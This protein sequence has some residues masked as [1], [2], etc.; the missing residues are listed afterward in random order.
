MQHVRLMFKKRQ[1]AAT[2]EL[3]A[4]TGVAAF[5]IGFGARTV[6]SAF[7]VFPNALWNTEISGSA[8][9]KLEDTWENVVLLII[10]EISFIGRVLFSKMH[11]R[12]QQAK[13]AYFSERG[14]DPNEHTFGDLSMVLV[15]DFGQLEPI[16]DWSLCDTGGCGVKVV[17]NIPSMGGLTPYPMV[18]VRE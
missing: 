5:N 14:L 17:C 2:V 9:R 3:T 16:D 18:Y 7:Q 10:D 15:G 6:C 13:R 1:I 8:L 4:Y 11:F 12:T